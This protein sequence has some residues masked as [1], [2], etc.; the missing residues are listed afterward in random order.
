[1]LLFT[2]NSYLILDT[3]QLLFL[4]VFAIKSI[5]LIAHIQVCQKIIPNY[6]NL[7]SFDE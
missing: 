6:D 5:I 2:N 3:N 4:I 1:M 7:D